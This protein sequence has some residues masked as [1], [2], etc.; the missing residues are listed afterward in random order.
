MSSP[1]TSDL[2]T[3]SDSWL[4]PLSVDL[5]LKVLYVT[6][7]HPFVCFMIPLCLRA[8]AVEWDAP[9][10][11]ASFAWATVVTMGWAAAS[12]NRRLAYGRPREIDLSEEVIVITGGAGGMGLLLAEVYGMRGATVAV[13]DVN[14]MENCEA[15]GVT[16]YRC[17]VGDKDQVAE[18]AREI[19]KEV[20]LTWSGGRSAGWERLTD[21]RKQ[22][23]TPTI[24]VNNAAIVVGKSML[25][26]SMEDVD[27]SLR[28]NMMAPF[29]CIKTFLPAMIR[30]GR[31]GTI[32]N[33]SSV[34]GHLGAA[35]LSDYAAAKAGM[36]AMHKSLAAEL[37]SSHPDI[38]MLLVTPG[39]LT[40]P[41]FY[42]VT[43]PNSFVAPAVEPVDVV[44][45]IV[46]LIDE[47]MGG[48]IG[49]PLYAR[50]IDWYNV[51][52]AAVQIMARSL[53]GVDKGMLTYKG[54][55]GLRREREEKS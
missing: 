39:Q 9:W 28:T 17:D 50:W 1:R 53:A 26:L 16:H 54:R 12:V 20:S 3:M 43:T 52:P 44:K 22:L 33:V 19:E 47:G 41:L 40:T 7:L 25:D 29:Y 37:R 13:L 8:R 51:L 31:G 15:R 6:L 42:G 36:T 18:A 21:M 10:M 49:T 48:S 4:A 30:N 2:R 45:E 35:H 5:V 32:V 14:D 27:R 38:R 23:G 24:L 46:T 11:I 34:L 55:A